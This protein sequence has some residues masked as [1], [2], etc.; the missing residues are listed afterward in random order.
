MPRSSARRAKGERRRNG[1]FPER[2]R[3]RSA[4]DARWTCRR[5]GGRPLDHAARCDID[6]HR[7]LR[8][9]DRVVAAASRAPRR[10]RAAE[11]CRDREVHRATPSL[12]RVHDLEVLDVDLALA[13]HRRDAG[14]RPGLVGDLDLPG[15]PPRS[16]RWAW[17]PGRRRACFARSNT[18]PPRPRR[19]AGPLPEARA[20]GRRNSSIADATS[21]RLATRIALHR[22]GCEAASRVRSRNPPAASSRISGSSASSVAASP[23]SDVEA[24]CGRWLT[25]ATRRSCRCGVRR[26]GR[27]PRRSI[28]PRGQRYASRSV[29]G[30]GATD[31]HDPVDDGRRGMLG[32]RAL[33]AA[34]RVARD[35][36]RTTPPGTQRL[37]IGEHRV[38]SRCRVRYDGRGLGASAAATVEATAPI[39]VATTTR[40]APATASSRRG[41]GSSP[42]MS[43]PPLRGRPRRDPSP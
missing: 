40:S 8:Q 27:A 42:P 32:P 35:E 20:V 24:T 17:P 9:P 21:P 26:T 22:E 15:P 37:D 1:C 5:D 25:I 38:P 36:S 2:S 7:A 28:Q 12:G 31:P 4:T 13:E 3:P 34:H 43:P 33:A 6:A 29:L 41:R 19:R 39:G 16:A 10:S 18:P 11:P 23:I 30:A 14:K